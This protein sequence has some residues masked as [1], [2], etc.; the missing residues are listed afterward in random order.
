MKSSIIGA[1]GLILALGTQGFAQDQGNL[2]ISRDSVAFGRT[3]SEWAAAWW[4]WA[5]SIPVSVHPLF[6]HGDC[7]TGQSGPVYFLGG[8]FNSASASR[9]CDRIT[10]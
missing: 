4:Q 5:L 2:A 9:S 6:D 3:Y 7:K 10:L 1:I 8:S